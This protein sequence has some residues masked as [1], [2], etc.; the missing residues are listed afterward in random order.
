MIAGVVI[1]PGW[2]W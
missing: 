1:V 2:Q